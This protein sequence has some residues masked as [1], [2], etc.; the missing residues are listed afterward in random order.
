MCEFRRAMKCGLHVW[1]IVK[2]A[3]EIGDLRPADQMVVDIGRRKVGARAEISV[4]GPLRVGSDENQ[5]ARCCR[6]L[7]CRFRRKTYAS[8]A[9]VMTKDAPERIVFDFSYI[10]GRGSE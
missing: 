10:A 1:W 4:H 7:L 6:P 9:D 3:F 8:R 2:I 5:A